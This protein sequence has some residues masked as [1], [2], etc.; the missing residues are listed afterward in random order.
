MS[1]YH[2]IQPADAFDRLAQFSTVIDVRS[3]AEFAEDHLPGAVNWPVLENDERHQVGTLYKQDPLEGRKVG[4]ALVARNIARHLDQH[5]E[6]MVKHW[7]PMVYCW[8][9]GQRSG[10]M[11]WFL[12]QIGFKSLQLVGGYKAFRGE[13]IRTLSSQPGTINFIVLCGRTG[14]GKTRLLHALS[15][16][17]HQV[18]DLEGLA[19]HR[20]SILGALPGQPQP[21][22]KAF[23]TALWQAMQALDTSRPVFVESES[24]KIGGVQLPESLHSRLRSQA[25]CV[26]VEMALDGRVQLLLEDYQHFQ[27]DP[28]GFGRLLEGL[29]ALRGR[30]RVGRWQML[31]QDGDWA[32]VFRELVVEHYDPGY[33]RSLLNHFPQLGKAP[34]VS[35][36]GGGLED[37]ASGVQ[38]LG[39]IAAQD[40]GEALPSERRGR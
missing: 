32:S 12:N 39:L 15:E 1:Q 28:A 31:A 8:R 3:P 6:V 4:A 21:S 7:R 30:E 26:W 18:L 36:A 22:Q 13:V 14:T 16:A 19:R 5:R 11:N 33:E 25:R 34:K 17:G 2:V 38:A 37:V 23:D 20:G 27:S 40:G 10:A 9:G 24:R 29:I 35:L